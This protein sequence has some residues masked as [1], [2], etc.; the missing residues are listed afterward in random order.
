MAALN[1][2]ELFWMFLH[3]INN[4]RWEQ[5]LPRKLVPNLGL[6]QTH[7]PGTFH[8]LDQMLHN[9]VIEFITALALPTAHPYHWQQRAKTLHLLLKHFSQL[10]NIFISVYSIMHDN[11]NVMGPLPCDTLQTI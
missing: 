1:K 5:K 4:S 10:H 9:R 8:Q 7:L 6:L 3:E 11:P 2:D